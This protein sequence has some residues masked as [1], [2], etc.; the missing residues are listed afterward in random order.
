MYKFNISARKQARN[1]ILFGLCFAGISGGL[2]T[3]PIYDMV[4]NQVFSI[5]LI[6]FAV[7][8]VFLTLVGL[9]FIVGGISRF[10]AGGEWN[11]Q[12]TPQEVIW[13]APPIAEYS[14]RANIEDIAFIEKVKKIKKRKDGTVKEKISL[15]LELNNCE[16]FD[17]ST[18]SGVDIDEFILSLK[19]LG[20]GIHEKEKT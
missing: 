4:Q 20:V 12:V 16:R 15:Y 8:L 3:A 5:D 7:L 2:A 11:I 9:V 10:I 14:F 19:N 18:Q 6:F 17:L 13:S 1:P